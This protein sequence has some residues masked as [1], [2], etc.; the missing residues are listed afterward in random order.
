MVRNASV[1]GGWGGGR[2]KT[3]YVPVG[4]FQNWFLKKGDRCTMTRV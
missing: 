4:W 3:M 1:C 2:V